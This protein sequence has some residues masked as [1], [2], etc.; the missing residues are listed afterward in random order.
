MFTI[1]INYWTLF[2]WTYL[3]FDKECKISITR[4]MNNFELIKSIDECKSYRKQ[5]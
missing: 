2:G 5:N 1:L 3:R 4:H